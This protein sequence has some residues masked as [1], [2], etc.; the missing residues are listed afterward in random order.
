MQ[1]F[2]Y[3]KAVVVNGVSSYFF[4]RKVD[5]LFSF[6]ISLR[7]NQKILFVFF[8]FFTSSSITQ[9]F[10]IFL[11]WW[12]IVSLFHL[13]TRI[14]YLAVHDFKCTKMW[15]VNQ[16]RKKLPFVSPRIK[17]EEGKVRRWI[18]R[19]IRIY[20]LPTLHI[21]I[22]YRILS[23]TSSYKTS[24]HSSFLVWWC[25]EEIN[26]RS[27]D[28]K[29]PIPCGKLAAASTKKIFFCLMV[30]QLHSSY[31]HTTT[32]FIIIIFTPANHAVK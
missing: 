9:K 22:A 31:H 24:S 18:V 12:H 10:L 23:Q 5:K 26:G 3:C 29:P 4:R 27:H 28:L 17:L 8:F 14:R 15:T 2:R 20:H 11:L 21:Y 16:I 19:D 6:Q 1:F 32:T 30:L 7:G 25:D 13:Y